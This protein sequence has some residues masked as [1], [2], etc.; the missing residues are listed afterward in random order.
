MDVL[1]KAQDR[2]ASTG[3]DEVNGLGTL[4]AFRT[5]NAGWLEPFTESMALKA[6][7]GG[8]SWA[9]WPEEF[10]RAGQR[11]PQLRAPAAGI[12]RP[13]RPGPAAKMPLERHEIGEGVQPAG[14]ARAKSGEGTE[15]V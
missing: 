8:R 10:R 1:V 7:F 9:T 6:H 5:R 4:A 11:R 2:F 12:L 15:P 3:A 14:L 13:G